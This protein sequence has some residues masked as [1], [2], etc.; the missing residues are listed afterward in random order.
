MLVYHMEE[1][2]NPR[3]KQHQHSALLVA[4]TGVLV[5]S[6]AACGDKP[7][8][9]PAV[10]P[11]DP[12]SVKLDSQPAPPAVVVE[13]KTEKSAEVGRANE[14]TA[15]VAKV[16]SALADDPVLK[17]LAIDAVAADGVIT[18]VGTADTLAH[19]N[20]AAQVASAVAGVKSVKNNLVILSGS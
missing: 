3:E 4:V 9:P 12:A 18:L 8:A 1:A 2:M 20:K 10:K 14:N 15:L 7:P 19:R 17:R 6:L 16:R 13:Q 5:L 11:V